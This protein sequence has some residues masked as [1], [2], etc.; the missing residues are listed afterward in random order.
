MG[1][2]GNNSELKILFPRTDDAMLEMIRTHAIA[3]P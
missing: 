3:T 2:M 1:W